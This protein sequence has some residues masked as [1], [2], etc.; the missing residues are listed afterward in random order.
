ML[1]DAQNVLVNVA[2][3]P[4][5]TLNEVQILMEEF[6]RHIGDRTRILF[7]T[8]TDSRSGNRLSVTILTAVEAEMRTP[9]APVVAAPRGERQSPPAA[10]DLAPVR[11]SEV[12][13]APH[14]SFVESDE[15]V[16]APIPAVARTQVAAR[17]PV[18]PA[19][20][21]AAAAKRAAKQEQMQFEPVTRGRFEKSEPTIVNGQDLDVPTFLRRNVRAK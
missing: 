16:A 7:G 15:E 2:G 4:N 9:V 17:A 6:N 5:M 18:A 1:E 8:A 12:E 11:D 19:A 10:R 20:A 3:G 14:I 21:D 13:H